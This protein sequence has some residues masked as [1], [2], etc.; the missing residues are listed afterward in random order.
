MKKNIVM[1]ITFLAICHALSAQVW[2][3]EVVIVVNKSNNLSSLS[4][5]ELKNIFLGKR[6]RWD[7]NSKIVIYCQRP[8]DVNQT[9]VNDYVNKSPQQ[10]Y[11]YWK[12]MLFTG[13]GSP[14]IELNNDQ[15]VLTFVSADQNAIGYISKSSVNESVRVLTIQ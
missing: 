7:D 2:A 6:S 11:T 1:F 3:G 15:D 4:S 9:F 12:K 13:K 10:F 8:G 5:S 14:P